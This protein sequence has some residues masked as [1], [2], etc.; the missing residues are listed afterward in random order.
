MTFRNSSNYS[1][2]HV[3]HF[4]SATSLQVMM[5]SIGL[6]FYQSVFFYFGTSEL[7]LSHFYLFVK[8]NKDIFWL[9]QE[10]KD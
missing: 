5:F 4:A 1:R 6:K 2:S 10:V 9:V 3:H 8:F 7:W